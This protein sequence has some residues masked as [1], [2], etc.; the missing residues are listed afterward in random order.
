MFENRS[1]MYHPPQQGKTHIYTVFY[2]ICHNAKYNEGI[3]NNYIHVVN[4]IKRF[5]R[6]LN[7]LWSLFITPV[8]WN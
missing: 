5:Y 6:G 1:I 3:M 8:N 7:R 2:G 4:F